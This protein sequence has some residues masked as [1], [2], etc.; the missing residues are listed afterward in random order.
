MTQTVSTPTEIIAEPPRRAPGAAVKRGAR[1]LCPACGEG[2]IFRSY[3]KVNPTCAACGEELHHHRADDFPAYLTIFAVGHLLG[4]AFFAVDEFW[5]ALPTWVHYLA[6][7][8]LCI[9]LSLWLL[10]IFK[11]GLIAYQW[12]LCMHGFDPAARDEASD[13]APHLGP[14]VA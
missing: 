12:A 1:G 10:P 3:L 6:W 7:P 11:G 5:P 13:A 4:A 8:T 2:L 14:G 9:I